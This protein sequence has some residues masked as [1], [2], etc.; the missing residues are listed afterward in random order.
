MQETKEFAAGVIREEFEKRGIEVKKLILFGSRA[1]GDART[2]SDWDFLVVI[3]PPVIWPEK[4]K[5]WLSVSRKLAK[6]YI[7]AELL[8]KSEDEYSHDISDK[9][10]VTYYANKEGVFA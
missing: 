7:A 10:K 5:I 8:I 2:D 1:R 4:R 9:G 6:H 3:N